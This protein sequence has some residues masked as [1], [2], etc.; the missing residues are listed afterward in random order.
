[1]TASQQRLWDL[2]V[3]LTHLA[4]ILCVAAA[5]ISYELDAMDWHMRNGYAVLTLVLFRIL[6][7]LFGSSSARFSHFLAGPSAVLAYLRGEGPARWPGH[8]PVGGWAVIVLLLALMVQ[9]GTGLF[10]NDDLFTEG[11]LVHLVSDATSDR[12]TGLHESFYFYGLLTLIGIH[13]AAAL[14]YLLR[15][16]QN[17]IVPMLTGLA[18]LDGTDA[19]RLSFAPLWRAGLLLAL[20]AGAI[21][22]LVTLA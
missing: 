1:M 7:G 20:S 21:W 5:W 15:R 16:K 12:L 17:L 18:P 22:G 8:S 4:L 11:P 2:P 3:R 10:A 14:F 9:A 13:V 19:S 6:W